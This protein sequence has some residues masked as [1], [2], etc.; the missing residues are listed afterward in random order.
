MARLPRGHRPSTYDGWVA[1][2]WS[3]LALVGAGILGA[4]ALPGTTPAPF[5]DYTRGDFLRP[6]WLV[7]ATL[8]AWPVFCAARASWW[9]AVPVVATLSA[10]SWYVADTAV[11]SLRQAG[12]GAG[13]SGWYLV[14]IGQVVVFVAVGLVGAWRCVVRRRWLRRMRRLVPELAQTRLHEGDELPAWE[15]GF[16][17]G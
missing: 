16:S 1:L 6:E 12:I 10:Q 17:T 13:S 4:L 15:E 9:V 11:D 3:A 14:A 7:L 2:G 5:T 8:L